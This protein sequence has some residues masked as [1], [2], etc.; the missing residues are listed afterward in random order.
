MSLAAQA[1]G[2]APAQPGPPAF[3]PGYPV[4][5]PS[6][7]PSPLAPHQPHQASWL[8]F[9]P[10]PPHAPRTPQPTDNYQF[11][12][13]PNNTFHN[14]AY[15]PN[16]QHHQGHVSGNSALTQP[17]AASQFARGDPLGA[18]GPSYHRFDLPASL[19]DLED[20]NSDLNTRVTQL[21]SH[22]LAPLAGANGREPHVHSFARRGLKDRQLLAGSVLHCSLFLCMCSI[23]INIL[24]IKGMVIFF[25]I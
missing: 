7:A 6:V 21:I 18:T 14:S 19:Q 4:P 12:T 22:T 20:H 8:T 5:P 1:L 24:C 15:L 2:P 17:P 13:A 23:Y 9:T 11:S 10:S 16:A 25:S 3:T